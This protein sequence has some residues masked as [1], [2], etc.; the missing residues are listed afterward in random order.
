MQTKPRAS[1]LMNSTFLVF[2]LTTLSFL[3]TARAVIPEPDNVVYGLITVSNVAVTAGRTN[4][5]VEVWRTNATP[6]GH[7][8]LGSY[9]M[10]DNP[11]LANSYAVNISLEAAPELVDANA[12]FPGAHDLLI[13]VKESR[14]NPT[15]TNYYFTTPFTVRE[16]GFVTNLNFGIQGGFCAWAA[17]NGLAGNSGAL[18]A[19]GDGI[20]N[21]NEYILGTSPVNAA[22]VFALAIQQAGA[23]TNSIIRY[24]NAVTLW[25]NVIVGTTNRVEISFLA[26]KA[27]GTGYEGL[28]RFFALESTTN[29]DGAWGSLA[30]YASLTGSNQTVRYVSTL[31]NYFDQGTNYVDLRTNYLVFGGTLIPTGSGYLQLDTNLFSV[32]TTNRSVTVR[33][34]VPSVFYRA[35]VWL[36]P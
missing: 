21:T 2:T 31:T 8:V 7:V 28:V 36:G 5:V 14:R 29:V 10:G 11:T 12:S 9:R 4:L 30:G 18:D 22:S 13:V 34:N 17:A 1:R 32:N 24:T 33:S 20:S 15:R 19:D 23:F 27:E 16:R 26:R 6:A 35:R 3:P 25:T